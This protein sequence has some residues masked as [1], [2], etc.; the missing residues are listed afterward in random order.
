MRQFS[1]VLGVKI[2]RLSTDQVLK[3][4]SS[5]VVSGKPHQ[6]VYINV[7]GINRFLSDK[8]YRKIVNEA[9]L[10]YPDGQGV[11]L[12]SKFSEKTLNERVNAGDFLPD[13]CRLCV[14]NEYKIYMLGSEKGVAKKAADYLC[15]KFDG[16][17]IVG[18]HDGFFG[19]KDEEGIIKEINQLSPDILLVGMGVP[20]QEKWIK[21]NLPLLNVP[22]CWGVGALFDYYSLRVKRAPRF[23]REIGL[24]WLFRFIIEPRRLWR[25]YLIG[26]FVFALRLF[27]LLTLDA[28]LISTAWIGAYWIRYALNK[29]I[30]YPINPF[31]VY[32]YALPGIVGLWILMSIFFDLYRRRPRIDRVEEFAVIVK[33]VLMGLLVTMAFSF[34]FKEFDFGRSVVLIFGMLNLFLLSLSRNLITF[35]DRI[36][37]RQEYGLKKVLIIGS[38]N[39]AQKIKKEIVDMPSGFEVVGGIGVDDLPNLEKIVDKQEI[40][41][42]YIADSDM[43]LKDKLNLVALH[44]NLDAEFKIVSDAFRIFANRIKLDKIM[45]VPILDLSSQ[46]KDRFYIIAKSLADFL[47]AII[48]ICL[49]LP[50]GIIIA[51]FIK[52]ESHGP[53]FFIQER[54]GKDFRLF[55]MLKFRTMYR[56]VDEYELSPNDVKDPRVTPFGRF[57]RL[58][59]LDELPQLF[60]VLKGDMSLVGPRPEMVFLVNQY[61]SW[62]KERLCVKPGITGLW[63]ITGR[64]DLPLHKNIEYDFY[65]IKHCSIVLD[66]LI[67]LKTVPAVLKKRGAY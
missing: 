65:Y 61:E 56:E 46:G 4:I 7:D 59:S 23:M 33:A 2:D 8:R 47:L 40:D 32:L 54:V 34:L 49:F 18:F 14:E 67:L 64:K 6:V 9:D 53:V 38:G 27:T 31:G 19:H 43:T 16:L 36:L 11:V 37:E 62:Q 48:G 41:E 55:K 12:A 57:L 42:I 58:W 52:L 30:D 51:I 50:I 10:V 45:D 13:L 66:L 3:Q 44:K 25:R 28:F 63:Q 5:F 15:K 21:R 60:N 39:L 22:V 26:N 17:K 20:L 24:E 35:I 29:I 1:E